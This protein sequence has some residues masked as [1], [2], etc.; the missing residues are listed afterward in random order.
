MTEH[1][2]CPMSTNVLLSAMIND[3]SGIVIV[4]IVD[5]THHH[6]CMI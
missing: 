2:L 4:I 6:D 1:L 5:I 3:D